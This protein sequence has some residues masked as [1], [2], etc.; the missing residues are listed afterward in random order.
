MRADDLLQAILLKSANDAS[1]ALAEKSAAR[2]RHLL[3]LM[4]RER[5][6][7]GRRIPILRML[8]ATLR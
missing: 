7:S 3:K 5:A 1:A 8:R 6:N 2:K 4:T